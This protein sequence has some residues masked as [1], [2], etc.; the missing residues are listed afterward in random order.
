MG[1][2]E[3]LKSSLEEAVEI[4][5]GKKSPA[6]VKRYEVADVLKIRGKKK[7]KESKWKS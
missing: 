1:I 5:V 6:R 4:Q 2:F 7:G 3:K